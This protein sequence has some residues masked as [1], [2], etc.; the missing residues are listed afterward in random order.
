MT[1]LPSRFG[2]G[3]MGPGALRFAEFLQ[4]AGQSLWQG[5]P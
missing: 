4:G 3:D 1:S 5:L 2:I